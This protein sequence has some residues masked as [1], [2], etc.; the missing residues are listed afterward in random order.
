[1][2]A[3]ASAIPELDEVI[4]NGSPDGRAAMVKRLGAFFLDGASR[5]NDDHVKV[6]DQ[7]LSRLVSDIETKA[8]AE[9]SQRLA[10]VTN[11]PV[12][13]VRRLAR[14]DDIEVAGPILERS[15]RISE[16]DL[17]H[18]ARIRSQAHLLA[19]AS[20]PEIAA[21]VT[22]LLVRRGDRQVARTLAENHGAR[23]SADGFA[24]LVG[25]AQTDELLAEKVVMRPDF[26]PLL[27]PEL[28]LEPTE[29]VQQPPLASA[30]AETEAETAIRRMLAQASEGAGA[31][32]APRDYTTA[33][34]LIESLHREH[35]LNE[36]AVLEFVRN[37]QF[38]ETVAAFACLCAVP[39]EVVER[40]LDCDR[41]DPVLILC[42][43]AG[44]GWPTA[45]EI[46]MA[47]RVRQALSSQT[48][49]AAYTN[50]EHLSP[51]TAKRVMRFWQVQTNDDARQG[52]R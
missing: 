40:I 23:L 41:P 45:K 17:V 16:S 32:A 44:W 36:A 31:C 42:K 29:A 47:S 18:V 46:I 13:V 30:N 15:T 19:I 14:D 49:D 12:G 43:A 22:D 8:R 52:M 51:T 26:P 6:F 39:M 34:R 28:V 25:R 7:V 33:Q 37:R 48:L 9:L 35:R 50:F 3:T 2:S 10:S 24:R 11:A 27:L 1:M 21:A 20:R 5:F 38:E 4:Q